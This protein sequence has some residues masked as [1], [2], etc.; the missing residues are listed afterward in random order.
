LG[1]VDQKIIVV[2]RKTRLAEVLERFHTR[3]QAKFYLR[4]ARAIEMFRKRPA[5]AAERASPT[6]ELEAEEKDF[7]E[8]QRED[9]VY[10]AALDALDRELDFGL[11]VQKVDRSFLPTL[12][13]G[14]EDIVVTVG[15]DGLVANTAKYALGHPIVAVNP[16]PERIDGI[17]LPFKTGE[18]A[19]AVRAIL[20][21]RAR[22]RE[23]TLARA[24]LADSQVLLAFNDLFIGNRTHVSAR[25]RIEVG[26]RSEP[27]SSS[28]VLVSTGA[29]STGWLSS[30]FN[31][32]RGV[33]RAFEGGRGG[34]PLRLDWQDPRL[35]FVV[36]EPFVS[37]QS[38][39]EIVAGLIEPGG[40]LVVESFMPSNGVIFS[41]GVE[42]DFLEF[43]TG[44]IARIRA[45]A[46]RARL[47]VTGR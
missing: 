22:Y 13:F 21:G 12:V 5:S 16:D 35:A 31:M 45:A 1:W 33:N 41:D 47:V 40:E 20:D 39:A 28:G 2:T 10:R 11:K 42:A 32:A 7:T 38:R 34:Q 14:P 15:Q 4:R 17:L 43:N 26:A 46:E 25:Y 19:G 8:Y 37:R 36:R 30:V 24:E 29:G 6:L 27:H 44:A 3:S 9:D 18:A 23:V